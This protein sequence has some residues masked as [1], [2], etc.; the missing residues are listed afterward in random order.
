[1]MPHLRVVGQSLHIIIWSE[2]IT[3]RE[4]QRI[5][6]QLFFVLD[7]LVQKHARA[8]LLLRL[9]RLLIHAAIDNPFLIHILS[10]GLDESR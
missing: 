10:F 6:S 2:R 9:Q 5:P 7:A 4:C 8:R 3:L 1:M